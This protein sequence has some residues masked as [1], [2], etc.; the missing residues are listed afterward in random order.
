MKIHAEFEER[1]NKARIATQEQI[2]RLKEEAIH[3]QRWLNLLTGALA[4]L[5][6]A[7]ALILARIN[8]DKQ[9]TNHLL[10]QKVKERTQSLE[11]TLAALQRSHSELEEFIV[12]TSRDI[13]S[14]MVTMRGL[15]NIMLADSDDPQTTRENVKQ[16]ERII[17]SLAELQYRLTELNDEN[18]SKKRL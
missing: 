12:K 6:I 18:H 1:E 7:L 9:K 16:L 17:T 10:E 3:R 13:Q 14:P 11:A 2:L 15:S 5:F 4:V 8:K